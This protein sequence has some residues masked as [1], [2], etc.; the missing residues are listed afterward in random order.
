MKLVRFG[1]RGHEKPGVLTN[2]GLIVNISEFEFDFDPDFFSDG[3]KENLQAWLD[4]NAAD[5]PKIAA[6]AVRL[7]PPVSLPGK[8]IC[9]GLN[10]M[11]HAKETGATP[12]SEP[13]IFQKA[14]S[15][16]SG[17]NDPIE[18]PRGST[19]TDWEVEL[20]IVIGKRAK[21]VEESEA[22]RCVA[23]YTV[24]NDVSERDFQKERCG[25]WTKGKSH[26][27]FAPLGPYLIT[28]DEIR[29]PNNLDL[30]LDVNGKRMQS[31]NTSTMIFKIPFLISYLSQFMT[32]L[33]GDIL[34]TGTPAG[35]GQGMDPPTFLQPG[36]VVELG[37]EGLGVQR[38]D[39]I[40]VG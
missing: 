18:I 40:S 25:Q 28:T 24:M 12:P 13:L 3:W 9:I 30:Y 38:H 4:D 14:A 6:D 23:G 1:E 17:P 8:I 39:V 15:A 36:D 34:S 11:D 22:M 10:Y 26:D 31:G 37:V 20:A 35:V 16:L 27:T 7:G 29:D 5:A 19:K 33:P 32:L 21:Y 2:D